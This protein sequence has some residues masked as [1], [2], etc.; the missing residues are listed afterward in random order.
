MN[1]LLP[2]HKEGI[3]GAASRSC[4]EFAMETKRPFRF[5][6][7]IFGAASRAELIEKSKRITAYISI[8]TTNKGKC[9]KLYDFALFF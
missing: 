5:G 4:R 9:Q 6:V 3:T 8:A 1:S 2:P 7:E